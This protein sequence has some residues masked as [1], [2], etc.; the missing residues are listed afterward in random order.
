[1]CALWQ[2]FNIKEIS[3]ISFAHETHGEIRRKGYDE[4]IWNLHHIWIQFCKNS[5]TIVCLQPPARWVLFCM[6]YWDTAMWLSKCSEKQRCEFCAGTTYC[7]SLIPTYLWRWNTILLC[8]MESSVLCIS[9][10][11]ELGFKSKL[12]F[13]LVESSILRSCASQ[14][15]REIKQQL[16]VAPLVRDWCSDE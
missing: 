4:R 1:M 2:R 7:C 15:K 11:I 5:W 3:L 10:Q 12:S 6:I 16:R 13:C 8:L 9:I 14:L